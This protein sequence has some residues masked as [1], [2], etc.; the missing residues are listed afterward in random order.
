MLAESYLEYKSDSLR[1]QWNA[2]QLSPALQ[3]LVLAKRHAADTRG[4]QDGARGDPQVKLV[5]YGCDHNEI[6]R[7][8]YDAL[9]YDGNGLGFFGQH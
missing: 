4:S 5:Q 9:Y 6:H 2:P 1:E 7:I 8:P 3:V